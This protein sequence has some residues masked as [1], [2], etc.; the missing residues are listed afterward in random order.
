MY[1]TRLDVVITEEML[2]NE[3]YKYIRDKLIGEKLLNIFN[4]QKKSEYSDSYTDSSN[5]KTPI[6]EEHEDLIYLRNSEKLGKDVFKRN[7]KKLSLKYHPDKNKSQ[8][9]LKIFHSITDIYKYIMEKNN[10]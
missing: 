1:T 7:Y 5:I 4:E 9:A 2:K 6:F 8:D 3:K 10:W